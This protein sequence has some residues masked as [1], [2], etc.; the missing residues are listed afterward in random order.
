SQWA[1]APQLRDTFVTMLLFRDVSRPHK[2]WED[3]WKALSEDIVHKKR[4]IFKY[5]DLQLTDEQIRNYC[6]LEIQELL[7]RYGRS[8][9]DFQDLP[10]PDPRLLTYMDNRTII[11]RLRSKQKIVL[12][13][14]SSGGRTAHSRFVIPLDL[15]ENSSCG[16]KQNTQLAELMQEVRLIIWDEAQ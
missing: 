10:R 16:T 13:V 3:N 9:A 14:A 1:L 4:K 7:N 12:A 11:S 15:M 2:L 5:P 6:L 8:L